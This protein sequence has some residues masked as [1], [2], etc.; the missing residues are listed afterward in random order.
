MA[1]PSIIGILKKQG[2]SI[3]S[4]STWW[5]SKIAF[6][7]APNWVT[8]W[9]RET[10]FAVKPYRLNNKQR[11]LQQQANSFFVDIKFNKIKV[12][13]WG[14]GPVIL[15]VHGWGGRALQMDSFVLPLLEKGYKVVAF[16]HKGHG[17]STSGFSSY[18][19]I[20]SGTDLL[21]AHYA[22]D[23]SG[24]IAHS[25]GSNAAFKASEKFEGNLQIAVV[26]PMENFPN[27]LEKMRK[28]IG[29]YEKLFANVIGQ[30]EADTG[31]N[32]LEQCEL[33]FEKIGRHDVLLVHDKLDRI[34]KIS[35]SHGLQSNLPKSVLMETEKLGHARILDNA[36]VVDRVVTHFALA[37]CRT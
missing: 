10:A 15:L 8:R 13:E 36:A 1:N 4:A 16:D 25:I 3:L 21:M 33:D 37:A 20:V 2:R 6:H 12:F 35:A 32:L 7:L 24:V 29:I 34:N 26:A 23:L 30:I 17:E 18:L 28:R 5:L 22:Q 31:L 27:L 9:T 19:E 14:N 11:E